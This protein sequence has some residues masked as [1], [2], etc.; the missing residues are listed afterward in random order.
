M[1]CS[2]V[3]TKREADYARMTVRGLKSAAGRMSLLA[4]NIDLLVGWP[5]LAASL[6]GSVAQI[7]T[8]LARRGRQTHG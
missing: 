7:E 6:R 3:A 1:K 5:R 4:D 2:L 8:E